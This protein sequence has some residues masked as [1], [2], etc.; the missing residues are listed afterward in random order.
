LFL[1]H[2]WGGGGGGGIILMDVLEHIYDDTNFLK[3]ILLKAPTGSFL[4][5]TVP[6]FQF[7]FSNHDVY[8]KHH[9]RYNRKQLLALI[10]SH[11]LYVEK[12]HYFY[13]SLFFVRLISLLFKKPDPQHQSGIGQW[14]F[15]EKHIVTKIFYTLLNFDFCFCAFF[16]R[17][18]IYLPGLSLLAVCKKQ[19]EKNEIA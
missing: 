18:R 12:C 7:L 3:E 11:N 14:S 19:G 2:F 17:F 6:S 13:A 16:A 5:I 8:L 10:D 4:F 9:R 15:N 1:R